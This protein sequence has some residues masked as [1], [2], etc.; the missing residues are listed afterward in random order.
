MRKKKQPA[1]QVRIAHEVYEKLLNIG[2]KSYSMSDRIN[3]LIEG[4]PYSKRE[5]RSVPYAVAQASVIAN[6][7]ETK[8]EDGYF[9][10]RS[11]IMKKV[12]EQLINLGWDKVHPDFFEDWKSWRCPIKVFLD[13]VIKGLVIKGIIEKHSTHG[14]IRKNRYSYGYYSKILNYRANPNL[15]LNHYHEYLVSADD[16]LATYKGESYSIRMVLEDIKRFSKLKLAR[17]KT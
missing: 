14:L 15:D 1:K 11:E 7:Q 6:M 5:I 16:Y 12:P 9:I 8:L 13:N 17:I 4:K 2:N 10:N 3:Y